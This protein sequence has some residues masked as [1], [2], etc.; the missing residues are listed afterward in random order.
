MEYFIPAGLQKGLDGMY[1]C[2]ICGTL[3]TEG[4]HYC[5]QCRPRVD[6]R[7]ER[8][9]TRVLLCLL[10]AALIALGLYRLCVP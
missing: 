10:V 5:E 6:P 7:T 3:M 9:L 8:I 2:S 4:R 1:R